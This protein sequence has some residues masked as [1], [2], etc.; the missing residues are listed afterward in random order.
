M[1]ETDEEDWGWLKGM[2]GIRWDEV[3]RQQASGAWTLA[4]LQLNRQE[5]G[6]L[7]TIAVWNGAQSACA[8]DLAMT[9][10][11]D[12]VGDEKEDDGG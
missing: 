6:W 8:H 2:G 1:I 9:W 11:R 5:V 4:E 3:L 10:M 12:C 7:E